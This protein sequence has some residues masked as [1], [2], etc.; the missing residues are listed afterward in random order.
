MASTD[1]LIEGRSITIS[2]NDLADLLAQASERGALKALKETGKDEIGEILSSYSDVRK[3][4]K[5]PGG[6][7]FMS[8]GRQSQL[9]QTVEELGVD[10][11]IPLFGIR[12]EP[13]FTAL[14][15]RSHDPNNVNKPGA[16]LYEIWI[17]FT[18]I[19]IL[20]LALMVAQGVIDG[21]SALSLAAGPDER[22][23]HIVEVLLL[24]AMASLIYLLTWALK[25]AQ[26]RLWCIEA[27]AMSSRDQCAALWV[28]YFGQAT[29]FATHDI[30]TQQY[31]RELMAQL[32]KLQA[33]NDAARSFG[34]LHPGR[35]GRGGGRRGDF[36]GRGSG[37]RG[38][39]AQQGRGAGGSS[40]PLASHP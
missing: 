25:I 21:L 34:Q 1:D 27:F 19:G 36:S 31:S 38:G 12:D 16:M 33:K 15:Q 26:A 32:M 3:L 11:D 40:A 2:Q 6:T 9:P 29:T 28:R 4:P 10:G 13:V 30:V 8:P 37:G 7:V 22:L 23:V 18:I 20:E 17:V 39:F 5:P 35:S 24:P 14:N